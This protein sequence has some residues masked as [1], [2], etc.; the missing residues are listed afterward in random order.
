MQSQII[1]QNQDKAIDEICSS[2]SLR[3]IFMVVGFPEYGKTRLLGEVARKME[4]KGWISLY[5]KLDKNDTQV[6]ISNKFHESLTKKLN[7]KMQELDYNLLKDF[8]PTIGCG[9]S[10]NQV[11]QTINFQLKE[12]QKNWIIL[13]D[14]YQPFTEE[15]D[16]WLREEFAT[17]LT[18]LPFT[19]IKIVFASAR[20]FTTELINQKSERIR[21][22]GLKAGPSL[23]LEPLKQKHIAFLINNAFKNQHGLHRFKKMELFFQKFSAGHPGI[24]SSLLSYIED[25]NP[26]PES[27]EDDKN[28]Y[29]QI[30]ETRYTKIVDEIP[31]DHNLRHSLELITTFRYLDD[32]QLYPFQNHYIAHYS[33]NDSQLNDKIVKDWFKAISSLIQHKLAYIDG[34]IRK[35]DPILR[36]LAQLKLQIFEPDRF[37]FLHRT[38]RF[39]FEEQL[40]NIDP[41][42]SDHKFKVEPIIRE[43]FYHTLQSVSAFRVAEK[44]SEIIN[45]LI[46][47]L[48]IINQAYEYPDGEYAYDQLETLLN[49]DHNINFIIENMNLSLN[50]LVGSACDRLKNKQNHSPYYE[51]PLNRKEQYINSICAVLSANDDPIGTCFLVKHKDNIYGLTCSHVIHNLKNKKKIGDL[52]WLRHFTGPI[53]FTAD[54]VYIEEIDNEAMKYNE[55]LTAPQDVTVLKVDKEKLPLYVNMLLPLGKATFEIINSCEIFGYGKSAGSYGVWLKARV[56]NPHSGGFLGITTTADSDE[57]IQEGM[58]GAPIVD[59]NQGLIIGMLQAGYIEKGHTGY[60]IPASTIQNILDKLQ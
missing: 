51:S 10:P 50:D 55:H 34:P 31:F 18:K 26:M 11:I 59:L 53:K 43:A 29:R 25:G 23:T 32:T 13:F 41:T 46:L 39:Y 33:L 17:N 20:F 54:I 30:V 38:A 5:I 15:L 6:S 24:I 21:K 27:P 36:E 49:S 44:D 52:V 7:D 3:K 12:S 2:K 57:H 19:D 42:N 45:S 58:S 48:T 16:D 8:K 22:W 1:Y 14:D 56:S 4:S 60:F 9:S 40:R 37:K 47:Y 35:L 28:I